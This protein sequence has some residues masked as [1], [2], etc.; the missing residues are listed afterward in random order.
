MDRIKIAFIGNCQAMSYL[1]LY[2]EFIDPEAEFRIIPNYH[3]A[4]PEG[5]Q[6]VAS[7][8]IVVWQV[9]TWAPKVN[10]MDTGGKVYFFPH[11][12]AP[13]LWP[14][15]GER[16]ARCAPS[17]QHPDGIIASEIGDRF[18]NRMIREGTPPSDAATLYLAD[19]MRAA[20]RFRE[21][22]L[23]QQ[24]ARDLLCDMCV[25]ERI[26]AQMCDTPLFFTPNHPRNAVILPI[27]TEL[28]SRMG[29]SALVLATMNEHAPP[30]LVPTT[31]LPIHP[32]VAETFGLRYAD[33]QSR[34]NWIA[35]ETLTFAEW[36]RSYMEFPG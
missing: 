34:Y 31:E 19:D 5:W 23:Q 16:H 18:L 20:D 36:I 21:L 10:D 29:A 7:A 30:A 27:A 22:V 3:P 33:C 24:R 9:L 15:Q 8:D 2:H 35:S 17:R 1:R 12:A 32:A 14:N 13:G 4:E 26:E 25:G 11:V 28:F 6:F